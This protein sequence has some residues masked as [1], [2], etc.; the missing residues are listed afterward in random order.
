MDGRCSAFDT[1]H[2]LVARQ[3]CGRAQAQTHLVL[4]IKT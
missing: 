2:Q 1:S 4:C 3:V